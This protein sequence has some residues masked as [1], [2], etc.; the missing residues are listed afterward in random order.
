[1]SAIRNPMRSPMRSPMRQ[2]L[3]NPATI[4]VRAVSIV[5]RIANTTDLRLISV[6]GTTATSAGP[7]TIADGGYVEVLSGKTWSIV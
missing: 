7:V 2:A 4:L 6:V 3:N 5:L 1:M